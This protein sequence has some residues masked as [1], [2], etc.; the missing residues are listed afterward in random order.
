MTSARSGEISA[1]SSQRVPH[2]NG[3]HHKITDQALVDF[4][5]TFVFGLVAESMALRQ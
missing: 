4:E 1:L 3:S 2:F 5:V